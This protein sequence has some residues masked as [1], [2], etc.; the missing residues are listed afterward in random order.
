MREVRPMR[1][2][3][4]LLALAISGCGGDDTSSD[5]EDP[6][7][8]PTAT[9]GAS[10][11]A[12]VAAPDLAENELLLSKATFED[13]FDA[14][15]PLSVDE[16]IL[17]CEKV[18]FTIELGGETEHVKTVGTTFD[19]GGTTYAINGAASTVAEE[20]GWKNLA[21]I[22]LQDVP[23]DPTVPGPLV[24]IDPFNRATLALCKK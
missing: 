8:K 13:E 9:S 1:L 18:E 17:R 16:G 20:N 4:V 2:T 23:D 11:P 12:S 15:W 7:S 3:L 14:E 22:R 24:N 5:T 10:T 6:S 21:V 19:A